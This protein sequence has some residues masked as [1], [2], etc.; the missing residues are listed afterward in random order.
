[1]PAKGAPNLASG[2]SRSDD[3]VQ[4]GRDGRH[5]LAEAAGHRI[6]RR[7]AAQIYTLLASDEA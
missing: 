5:R 3:G 1:M 7:N 2:D 4:T 6:A